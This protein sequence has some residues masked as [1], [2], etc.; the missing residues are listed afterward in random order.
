MVEECDRYDFPE[1]EI[2]LHML[3]EC[4]PAFG[5]MKK[6]VEIIYG[7]KKDLSWQ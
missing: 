5:K 3:G 2:W 1:K 6:E 4:I 7:R